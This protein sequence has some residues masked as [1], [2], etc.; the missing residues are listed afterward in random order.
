MRLSVLKDKNSYYDGC[1]GLPWG[2]L[3]QEDNLRRGQNLQGASTCTAL[4]HCL[5]GCYRSKKRKTELLCQMQTH[6]ENN[7]CTFCIHTI[8]YFVSTLMHCIDL[9]SEIILLNRRQRSILAEGINCNINSASWI[10][11]WHHPPLLCSYS[12]NLQPTTWAGLSWNRHALC[13]ERNDARK[14]EREEEE[15]K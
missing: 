6:T 12:F 3:T 5:A 11:S 4:I 7:H 15:W 2:I 10:L 1:R 8:G 13:Q 14:T 9:S